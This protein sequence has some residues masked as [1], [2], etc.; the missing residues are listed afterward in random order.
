[1][2]SSLA[3]R[4]TDCSRQEGGGGEGKGERKMC[5]RETEERT[6]RKEGEREGD[7]EEGDCREKRTTR[8]SEERREETCSVQ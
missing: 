5:W 8:G 2:L 1:M 6:R 4:L 7:G 3:S